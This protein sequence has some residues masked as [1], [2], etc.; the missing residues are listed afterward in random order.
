MKL[1]LF[2]IGTDERPA[3]QDDIKDFKRLLEEVKKAGK[4][5]E[6]ACVL[7]HHCVTMHELELD[8]D[9]QIIVLSED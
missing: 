1:V 9:F 8:K 3:S 6:E 5:H 7:T 4:S 2:K